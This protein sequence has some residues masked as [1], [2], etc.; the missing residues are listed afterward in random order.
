MGR[1]SFEPS[2]LGLMLMLLAKMFTLVIHIQDVA[3]VH[4]FKRCRS[5]LG[6]TRYII[7][8]VRV[9]SHTSPLPPS[10]SPVPPPPSTVLVDVDFFLPASVVCYVWRQI[11]FGNAKI[12]L[13]C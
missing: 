13:V 7:V 11:P 6:V 10:P 1:S 5:W 4:S 9:T 2:V 8:E 12:H 3:R